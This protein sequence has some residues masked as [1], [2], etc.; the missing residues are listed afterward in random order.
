MNDLIL[1]CNSTLDSFYQC[2]MY[3]KPLDGKELEDW[4]RLQNGPVQDITQKSVLEIIELSS[5]FAKDYLI[6]V[7]LLLR[8]TG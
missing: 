7:L 2:N 4:L 6:E 8:C 5:Q 1:S 3:L